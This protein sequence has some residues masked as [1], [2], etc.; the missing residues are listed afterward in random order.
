MNNKS[1][2]RDESLTSTGRNNSRPPD[3]PG[4]TSVRAPTKV[5]PVTPPNLSESSPTPTA[6]A[7]PKSHVV[8]NPRY[9]NLPRVDV[10]TPPKYPCTVTVVCNVYR[11]V[12]ETNTRPT[13]YLVDCNRIPR[14]VKDPPCNTCRDRRARYTSYTP[15]ANRERRY[16]SPSTRSYN[17]CK[18]NCVGVSRVAK[19]LNGPNGAWVYTKGP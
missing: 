8:D 18:T 14:K 13:L 4:K 17:R 10:E 6:T 9:T 16:V 19:V 7:N 5:S 15:V 1:Y 3:N 11:D 12:V 2:S